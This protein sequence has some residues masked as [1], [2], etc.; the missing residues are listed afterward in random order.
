[1]RRDICILCRC[2]FATEFFD[3]CGCSNWSELLFAPTQKVAL[4]DFSAS[5][6]VGAESGVAVDG[7]E[8][9]N[10]LCFNTF[11]AEYLHG[12]DVFRQK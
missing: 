7:K 9:S 8:L 1:M 3:G 10:L 5:C 4:S 2:V 6:I 11:S 12:V